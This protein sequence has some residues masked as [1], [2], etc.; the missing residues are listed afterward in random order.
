MLTGSWE[1]WEKSVDGGKHLFC[2]GFGFLIQHFVQVFIIICCIE[3]HWLRYGANS[4]VFARYQPF[5]WS[6][7]AVCNFGQKIWGYAVG[8]SVEPLI[9][10]LGAYAAQIR[11]SSRNLLFL[12]ACLDQYLFNS[13]WRSHALNTTTHL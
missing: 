10:R 1:G 9:H 4:F 13:F 6:I 11:E 5:K 7:I 2:S 12:N 3:L 8:R